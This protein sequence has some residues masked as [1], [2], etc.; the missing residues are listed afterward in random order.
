M[1]GLRDWSRFI[2]LQFE[3]GLLQRTPERNLFFGGKASDLLK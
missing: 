2:S 1:A 3:Y